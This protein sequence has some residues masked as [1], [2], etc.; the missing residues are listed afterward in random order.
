MS[1]IG[2]PATVHEVSS[3]RSQR[4]SRA[5]LRLST[6]VTKYARSARNA[7][8]TGDDTPSP[9]DRN[10]VSS[11]VFDGASAA[12][13]PC[14]TPSVTLVILSQSLKF[15]NDLAS[16]TGETGEASS[17]VGTVANTPDALSGVEPELAQSWQ[18]LMGLVLD[19]RWRWSEVATE[20]G[21]SQ[22]ALRALLAIEPD[23]ARPQRDLAK[24]MNCDPSY[25]TAM[26]DDLEQAG[27]AI[28]QAS[29]ED[30][31]IKVVA[32]TAIGITAL[33]TARD[34]LFSPPSQLTRLPPAQQRSLAKLLGRALGEG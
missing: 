28:R 13:V 30:R 4:A 18:L 16:T 33:H 22:A 25:V 15:V 14:S 19:Q 31:R 2:A 34:G 12:N 27:Y 23:R 32:L 7:R 29:T 5:A 26:I 24:A 21:I 1:P 20:L 9:P 10:V 17:K 8:L 6:A 11:A 3:T